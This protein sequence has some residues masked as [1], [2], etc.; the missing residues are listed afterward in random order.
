[1]HTDT[2]LEKKVGSM[3]EPAY[4]Y[5]DLG[6]DLSIN[7][8]E[9]LARAVEKYH[10]RGAVVH[11]G[12]VRSMTICHC[13]K[14]VSV[15]DFPYGCGRENGKKIEARRVYLVGDPRLI[16]VDIVLNLWAL[17]TRSWPMIQREIRAV[18]DECPEKEIKVIC[19]M[20]FVWQYCKNYIPRLLE[21]LAECGVNVIKDWT[22]INNFSRPIKT[23]TESRLEYIQYLRKIIDECRYP[24]LIK[25]AGGINQD[26]VSLFKEAGA[27][28]FGVGLQKLPAVFD[29]LV[30]HCGEK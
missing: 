11:P 22:T 21:T 2:D 7:P 15:I 4:L 26:N 12:N 14:I 24:F 3:L 25:A 6:E 9:A 19:Q 1:M 29:V 28:I 8:L 20:P 17:Q 16:G 10:C 30:K 27:D 23:D 13:D 18:K 5:A